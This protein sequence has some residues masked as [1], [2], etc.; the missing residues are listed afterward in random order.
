[1][2]PVPQPSKRRPDESPAAASLTSGEERA[3]PSLAVERQRI[4]LADALEASHTLTMDELIGR[5]GDTL[6]EF[7]RYATAARETR[8]QR[9]MARAEVR[10]VA[11][12]GRIALNMCQDR[13]EGYLTER[14][15]ATAELADRNRQLNEIRDALGVDGTWNPVHVVEQWRRE[16]QRLRNVEADRARI[17]RSLSAEVDRLRTELA[18]LHAQNIQGH[19]ELQYAVL[20]LLEKAGG[21]VRFTP[22]DLLAD[23]PG[24]FTSMPDVDGGITLALWGAASETHTASSNAT[25][26]IPIWQEFFEARWLVSV[27]SEHEPDNHWSGWTDVDADARRGV[28]ELGGVEYTPAEARSL[29]EALRQ[30]ADHAEQFGHG[31]ARVL[32]DLTIAGR[33]PE[34]DHL[35]VETQRAVRDALRAAADRYRNQQAPRHAHG[36][37][38]ASNDGTQ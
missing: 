16:I 37:T 31:V 22:K 4:A 19:R 8:Q 13:A 7:A 3:L 11:E 34:I 1:M 2:T 6:R 32:F 23:M 12:A 35:P 30:A 26:M 29:A 20:R 9:D 14:D 24:G 27:A 17:A 25:A 33:W 36:N 15:E 28:V 18:Q 5:A 21:S 10:R 38:Q